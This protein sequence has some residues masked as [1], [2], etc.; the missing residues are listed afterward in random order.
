MI[1]LDEEEILFIHNRMIE[2]Y[3]GSHGSR[4][5]QRIKSVVQAPKQEV[6]GEEQYKTVFEKAAVYARN[7]I[8]DHPFV[9][10]NKRTGITAALIFI[11][12]NGYK[13]TA[14]LGEIEDFAV[15][16]ATKKPS[17][18]EIAKWLK[19]HSKWR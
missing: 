9:D 4:D 11:E 19:T 5:L 3:G 13:V 15:Y 18:E 1:Y 16:V 2:S 6:F 8:S 7:I 17:I 12:K 10:G 14:K